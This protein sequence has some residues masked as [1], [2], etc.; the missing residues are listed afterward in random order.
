MLVSSSLSSLIG[1]LNSSPLPS[2]SGSSSLTF[3]G[4]VDLRE[5]LAGGLESDEVDARF[6]AAILLFDL[7]GEVT[8]DE[9]GS[10]KKELRSVCLAR[11]RVG[12]YVRATRRLRRRMLG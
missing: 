12:R 7:E 11:L 4:E 2:E 9:G 10:P 6:E 5:R 3:E 8:G 1:F